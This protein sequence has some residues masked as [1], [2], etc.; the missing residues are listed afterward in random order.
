MP[1]YPAFSHA[2]SS[3][4]YYLFLLFFR[5]WKFEGWVTLQLLSL[6]Q[7]WQ[8]YLYLFHHWLVSNTA[9]WSIKTNDKG[10]TRFSLDENTWITLKLWF[11]LTFW[12]YLYALSKVKLW[13]ENVCWLSCPLSQYLGKEPLLLQ[14][15]KGGDKLCAKEDQC[16]DWAKSH[17][18]SYPFI[19][20]TL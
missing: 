4:S 10:T 14:S 1:A 13:T 8:A 7:L 19:V 5:A 11:V 9:I 18:C 2:R 6:S 3:F 12:I 17:W 15:D 16:Q 20:L